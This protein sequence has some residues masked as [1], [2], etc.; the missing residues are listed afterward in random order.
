MTI[1]G[2]AN[3]PT[4]TPQGKAP[5]K[6]AAVLSG[7]RNKGTVFVKEE[8]KDGERTYRIAK[9]QPALVTTEA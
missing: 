3:E 7:L 1:I 8:R 2:I 5:T 4:P 6:S 9:S